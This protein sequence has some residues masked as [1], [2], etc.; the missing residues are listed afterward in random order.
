MRLHV[1]TDFAGDP[2]DACALAMVLGWPDV[3]VTGITTVADPDG[4]RADHVAHFLGLLGRGDIPVAVGAGRSLTTGAAM[5][6]VADPER[7]WGQRVPER[8]PECTAYLELLAG[9]I[10]A[11]ATIAAIGPWTNLA[12]LSRER[13]GGLQDARVVAMGGW[14]DPPAPGLPRW[15]AD[16]D[17][18][19][20]CDTT[21]A[22]TLLAACE[23]LTLSALPATMPASLR[24]A[25]L[26]RLRE[27]GSVGRLLARQS[28]AHRDD[29]GYAVLG[30]SAPG[31]PDDL[32]NF[33]WDPVACAVALGWSGA[34]VEETEL[35]PALSGP[36]LSFERS[37]GGR[38]AHVL[39]D[40]DGEAFT[41]TWLAAVEA[42][43]R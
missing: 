5:G 8:P 39:V 9:S 4:R 35:V 22:A 28:L 25:D 27:S 14:V 16:R 1:D 26:D 29:N 10:D 34:T 43:Q 30:P 38:R 13:P 36:V 37:A 20:Q 12:L 31:L 21:A 6:E 32:V 3:E 41:T 19:V 42:A 40:V 17:W 15:E 18:N 11:G 23:D 33:H 7:Y 2:D 24:L